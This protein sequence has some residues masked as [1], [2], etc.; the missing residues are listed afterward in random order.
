MHAPVTAPSSST[1]DTWSRRL[2]VGKNTAHH[3]HICVNSMTGL[4]RCPLSDR[5]HTSAPVPWQ[6]GAAL[7]LACI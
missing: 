4:G 7:F 6:D 3:S 5:I 1:Q 2:S